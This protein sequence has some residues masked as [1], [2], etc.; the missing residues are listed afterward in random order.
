MIWAAWGL[1]LLLAVVLLI[2]DLAMPHRRRMKLP[3]KIALLLC[4]IPVGIALAFGVWLHFAYEHHWLGL[5]GSTQDA[6]GPWSASPFLE[7]TTGYLLE[8]GLSADNV[9]LFVLLM[10]AFQTPLESQGFVLF[11]AVLGAIVLRVLLILTGLSLVIH[12]PLLFYVLGAFLVFAGIMMFYRNPKEWKFGAAVPRV[13][14]RWVPLTHMYDGNRLFVLQDGR[15]YA[16][17]LL[18]VMILIALTDVLFALDS[19]PSILGITED[20]MIV[21][22]SNVFAVLALHWLYFVLAPLMQ[23]LKYVKVGLAVILAFIGVKMLL[24]GVERLFGAAGELRI[25]VP[26][27]LAFIGVVL[28]ISIAASVIKKPQTPV[29]G[30]NKS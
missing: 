1:F 7:Y 6:I 25:T 29:E 21:I 13:I 2:M 11:W 20:L 15:R 28:A 5:A 16:T 14:S 18:L 8:L 10:H 12:I 17:P 26:W 3:V 30:K 9:M 19:I 27:S 4:L 22:S 23:K 24:P